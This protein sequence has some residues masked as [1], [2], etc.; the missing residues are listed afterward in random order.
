MKPGKKRAEYLKKRNAR[1][2]QPQPP[3]R[4]HRRPSIAHRGHLSDAA[5][6]AIAA[7]TGEQL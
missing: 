4:L 3:S 6:R 2:V 7:V 1:F 5:L